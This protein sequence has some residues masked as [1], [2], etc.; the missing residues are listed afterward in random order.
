MSSNENI[1]FQCGLLEPLNE[2]ARQ[3]CY[4][5]TWDVILFSLS[6]LSKKSNS[7]TAYRNAIRIRHERIVKAED[8][9]SC[10][11]RMFAQL[12]EGADSSGENQ[13]A[14]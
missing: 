13:G 12:S 2:L 8:E 6:D 3:H 1:L 10:G 11:Q 5:S 14:S 7:I 4:I 9:I